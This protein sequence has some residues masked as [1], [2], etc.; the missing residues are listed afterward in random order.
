MIYI[1]HRVNTQSDLINLHKENGAEID[2][3]L[4]NGKIILTHDP[5]TGGEEFESWIANYDHNV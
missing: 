2:L 3:R 4:Q 1:K 5:Y